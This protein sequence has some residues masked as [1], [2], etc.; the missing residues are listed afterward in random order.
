[1]A[2]NRVVTTR[3]FRRAS[4]G[5]RST[6]PP[7]PEPTPRPDPDPLPP[8]PVPP[9]PVPPGPVPPG[10]GPDPI[11]PPEPQPEPFPQLHPAHRVLEEHVVRSGYETA[12][13]DNESD[14]VTTR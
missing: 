5:Y 1:M 2:T 14:I 12:V 3:L 8:G 4:V 10:P 11:P 9:G 6:V 13:R 7:E